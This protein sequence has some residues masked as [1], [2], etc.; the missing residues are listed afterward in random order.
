RSGGGAWAETRETGPAPAAST[1]R[2]IGSRRRIFM[3]DSPE[4]FGW[5]RHRLRGVQHIGDH[6]ALPRANGSG[7]PA[8]TTPARRQR[9]SSVPRR[10]PDRPRF[11]TVVGSPG[12][13]TA[14]APADRA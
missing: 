2:M 14:P 1:E 6:P 11:P 7:Q 8:V 12:L 4:A 13:R 5:A 3:I 9:T 10:P